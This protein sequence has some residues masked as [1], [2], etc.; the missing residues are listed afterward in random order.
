MNEFRYLQAAMAC[1]S[2]ET[3]YKDWFTT[4]FG[5]WFNIWRDGLPV[6]NVTPLTGDARSNAVLVL[7]FGV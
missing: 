5:N 1:T 2:A 6:E 3:E 4:T 7:I